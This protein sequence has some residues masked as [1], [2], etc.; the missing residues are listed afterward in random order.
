MN[1]VEL[2]NHMQTCLQ[3]EQDAIW[4]ELLSEIRP[5][6]DL[7]P[8]HL[9]MINL[10]AALRRTHR[11]GRNS[12]NS[13]RKCR[14]ALPMRRRGGIIEKERSASA[15][16]IS[17]SRHRNTWLRRSPSKMFRTLSA[18]LERVTLLTLCRL[19]CRQIFCLART[20]N[21]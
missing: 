5:N 9:E 13:S 19:V 2:I 15:S 1:L 10:A 20:V 17:W 3:S 14:I 6:T 12:E 8:E 4:K 16:A 11:G 18:L 7:Q 21:A